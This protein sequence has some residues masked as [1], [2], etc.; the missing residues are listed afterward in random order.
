MSENTPV[1]SGVFFLK[2]F[3]KGDGKNARDKQQNQKKCF[4]LFAGLVL[5]PY[6]LRKSVSY[7]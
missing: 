6:L 4:L 5:S 1:K 2:K 7:L 3:F